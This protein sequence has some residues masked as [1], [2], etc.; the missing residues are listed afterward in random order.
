MSGADL[1]FER[2]YPSISR[3]IKSYGWV[4]LGQLDWHRDAMVRALDEGGLVWEGKA[5]YAALDDLLRDL[6]TGLA[7]WF[8]ENVK[9]EAP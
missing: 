3:W 4:E 8:A 6:E 2:A 1:T 7:G 5:E 9:Q